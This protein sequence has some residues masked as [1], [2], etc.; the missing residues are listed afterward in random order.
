M[1]QSAV[2]KRTLSSL[3]PSNS[4]SN[5]GVAFG[6]HPFFIAAYLGLRFE[7]TLDN[8]FILVFLISS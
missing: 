4:F 8:G 1:H 3:A 7:V 6:S 2:L 5:L